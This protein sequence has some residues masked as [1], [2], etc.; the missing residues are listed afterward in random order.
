MPTAFHAAAGLRSG[1]PL[2]AIREAPTLK[3]C[4]GIVCARWPR[5]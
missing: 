1:R 2:T 5:E 3:D 4:D